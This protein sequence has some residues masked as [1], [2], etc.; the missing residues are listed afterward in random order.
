MERRITKRITDIAS[1]TLI[2]LGTTLSDSTVTVTVT[3]T[4]IS[5]P[6][7]AVVSAFAIAA[8]AAAWVRTGLYGAAFHH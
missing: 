3:V 7:D 2:V 4:I 1:C 6:H 8:A 5:Y